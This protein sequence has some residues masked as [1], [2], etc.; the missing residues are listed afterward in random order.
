MAESVQKKETNNILLRIHPLLRITLSLLAALM[1]FFIIWKKRFG[2]VLDITVLWDVFAFSYIIICWTVFFKRKHGEIIKQANKD[3]GSRG[4]VLG[5]VLLASVASMFAV[6][7][8]MI[9]K[10]HE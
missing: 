5:S 10:G 7:M 4:F 2:V 6:S 1:V 9:A 8:L 3:D